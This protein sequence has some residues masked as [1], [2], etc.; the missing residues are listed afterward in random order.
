M[1]KITKASKRAKP[2][3]PKLNAADVASLRSEEVRLRANEK[4]VS[5][6][7]QEQKYRSEYESAKPDVAPWV[8]WE[9]YLEAKKSEARIKS[10]GIIGAFMR[11]EKR[12]AIRKK[13][14]ISAG[15][16]NTILNS[17]TVEDILSYSLGYI[18]SFQSAAVAAI[19]H[20]LTTD[21]DGALAMALLERM[22]VFNKM[23]ELGKPGP[24]AKNASNPED[25][26]AILLSKD[27]VPA[28]QALS[29][30]QKFVVDAFKA[31]TIDG[32]KPDPDNGGL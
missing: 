23:G 15:K 27:S 14:R 3:K 6:Y 28:R 12:E 13:Y 4:T 19:L 30:I 21:H 24:Q 26:I 2:R 31:G 22:G 8:G 29:Q 25:T 17:D 1:R 16:L 7:Q 18:Y 32:G 11:G 10:V 5:D 20:R 9:E